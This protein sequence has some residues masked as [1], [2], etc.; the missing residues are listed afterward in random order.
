MEEAQDSIPWAIAMMLLGV[1]CGP[2]WYDKSK[3][4]DKKILEIA[5][6]VKVKPDPI[7]DKASPEKMIATVEVTTSRGRQ[8]SAYIELPKGDP[9]NPMKNEELRKKFMSLAIPILGKAQTEK[10]TRT[11][12]AL[13]KI[14]SVTEITNLLSNY[15]N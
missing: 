15:H 10:L 8:F 13:D 3:F 5:H 14:E 9:Q 11:I 2:E 7:A 1:N 12:N 6:K 4:R